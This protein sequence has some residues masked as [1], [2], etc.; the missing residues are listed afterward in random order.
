M[1]FLSN[2]RRAIICSNS[3]IDRSICSSTIS[4]MVWELLMYLEKV[5]KLNVVFMICKTK[6]GETIFGLCKNVLSFSFAAF[7]SVS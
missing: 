7:G 5:A 1:Y 6:T 4:A 3:T 2:I